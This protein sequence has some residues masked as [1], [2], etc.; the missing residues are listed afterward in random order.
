MAARAYSS[1]VNVNFDNTT[2]TAIVEYKGK[3]FDLSSS[4]YLPSYNDTLAA[5]NF[6]ASIRSLDSKDHPISV[7]IEVKERLISTLSINTYPCPI[8]GTNSTCQGPNGTR[9]SAS[10]NNISFVAPTIDILESYYYNV[11]G[12]PLGKNFPMFPP[13]LFNYTADILPLQL[14]VPE[15]GTHVVVLK[16][17]PTVE[18]VFQGTNVATGIDHPMHLHGFSF[19]TVG[20]GLG[21]FNESL[22]PLNYNLVDPPRQNTVAVPKRG[23]AAIRFKA[24]NP[25]QVSVF[26]H[27][28]TS[29][30]KN[31]VFF[32][33]LL[34]LCLP[35]L[36]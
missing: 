4:P 16:Y 26:F 18:V 27:L 3:Y 34:I 17:N 29:T 9:F 14:E 23:W 21:N 20:M 35:M 10:M 1:G 36:H 13:Y 19:Y 32:S 28:F 31:L 8:N 7:P 12:V 30:I 25:G 24:D 6:S 15:N 2:A 5:V 11:K 33:S 22:D